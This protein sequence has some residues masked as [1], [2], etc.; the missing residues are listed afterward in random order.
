[1]GLPRPLG[2]L[3]PP[4]RGAALAAG[5]A[6]GSAPGPAGRGGP[7]HPPGG[8]TGP[9][10][11]SE[12]EANLAV[13]HELERLLRAAGA[14]VTLT[15]RDGSARD[16]AARLRVADSLD[17]DLLVSIH[18]NALPDGVNPFRN[19]GTSTFYFHPQSAALARAVQRYLAPRL[20]LPDLGAARADLALVRGTWMPSVL[21]E[22]MFMILPEQEAALRSA[23]GR[24]AYAEGVVAGLRRFLMGRGL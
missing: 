16:L 22:G 11:L 3:R 19:H 12:A 14:L 10:G 2:A 4:R 24:R 13:A 7:G 5:A 8:S 20:G 1:V 15:R 18:N 23:A 6:G 21:V 17:A 9:T